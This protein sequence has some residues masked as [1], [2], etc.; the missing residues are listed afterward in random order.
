[1]TIVPSRGNPWAQ[2]IATS[3]RHV[4]YATSTHKSVCSPKIELQ[5]QQE[6][7]QHLSL[8]L[9]V[10][11]ARGQALRLGLQLLKLLLGFSVLRPQLCRLH[12]THN[13]HSDPYAGP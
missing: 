1:M 2:D 5:R 6:E 11:V 4:V 13:F 8:A 9:Q 10:L 3:P 12:H 7:I